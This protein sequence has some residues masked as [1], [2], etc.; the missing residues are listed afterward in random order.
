[1]GQLLADLEINQVKEAYNPAYDPRKVNIAVIVLEVMEKLGMN[2]LE[3][4]MGTIAKNQQIQDAVQTDFNQIA[5]VL[6]EIQ[7]GGTTLSA[8]TEKSLAGQLKA[9]MTQLYG[10]Y[11]IT[12]M[13]NGQQH[14]IPNPTSD[15]AKF[16]AIAG[17]NGQG[18]VG[19]INDFSS[20]LC[21][22]LTG[23]S[24][25]SY[26]GN[27]L[28]NDIF[29]YN[30]GTNSGPNGTNSTGG[31]A[32]A[33]GDLGNW[34]AVMSQN[35]ANRTSLSP[36]QV[37]YATNFYTDG[38]AATGGLGGMS[39]ENSAVIQTDTTQEG[40]FDQIGQSVISSMNQFTQAV[41]QALSS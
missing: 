40:S 34:V 10:Q 8:A 41:N 19:L 7:Q 1:M 16:E 39:Q 17:T 35:Y 25:S 29:G 28:I 22:A 37:D 5:H 26:A 12:Y 18:V 3:N 11:P 21:N 31:N 36:G 14:I 33:G 4:Q 38:Q 24:S 20:D 32:D 30:G 27:T 13:E 23:T 9:A 6:T 15:L 2:P